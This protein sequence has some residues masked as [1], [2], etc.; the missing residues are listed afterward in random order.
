MHRIISTGIAA[1]LVTAAAI[2]PA[3]LSTT[4][5]P[6]LLTEYNVLLERLQ[7][8]ELERL[9]ARMEIERL[10]AEMQRLDAQRSDATRQAKQ[11][12]EDLRRLS[13]RLAAES[14]RSLPRG[15]P[16]M[17]MVDTSLRRAET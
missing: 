15:T 1:G 4:G 8:N 2:A 11:L 12:E 13:A 17:A 9:K 16:L 3:Q 10:Q 5:A 6:P 7:R 14:V